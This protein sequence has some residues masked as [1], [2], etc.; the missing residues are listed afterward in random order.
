MWSR[1]YVDVEKGL[2]FLGADQEGRRGGIHIHTF[3][4][5]IRVFY[6][7]LFYLLLRVYLAP[8]LSY[9]L[10]YF[11]LLAS[12]SSQTTTSGTQGWICLHV[13]PLTLAP[14]RYLHNLTHV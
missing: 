6:I 11:L 1:T 5:R 9:P 2:G 10:P 4:I 14:C 3:D 12:T 8:E 7:F 13:R